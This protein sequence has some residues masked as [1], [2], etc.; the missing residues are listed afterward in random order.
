[1]AAVYRAM[2]LVICAGAEGIGLPAIEALACGVSVMALDWGPGAEWARRF[3]AILLPPSGDWDD[4]E[5]VS[6]C[7]YYHGA[8]WPVPDWEEFRSLL[9]PRMEN[10]DLYGPVEGTYAKIDAACGL[11]AAGSAWRAALEG[12]SSAAAPA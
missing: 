7:R 5:A 6:N 8:R 10:P 11:R 9:V 3:G 12:L 1:M 2:D 4:A